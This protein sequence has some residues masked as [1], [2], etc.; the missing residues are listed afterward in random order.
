MDAQSSQMVDIDAFRSLSSASPRGVEESWID[1]DHERLRKCT[2][3][4]TGV[5]DERDE[6]QYDYFEDEDGLSVEKDEDE[7][8]TNMVKTA[9][10]VNPQGNEPR[11][12][13]HI[14]SVPVDLNTSLT[15]ILATPPKEELYDSATDEAAVSDEDS[16]LLE[17]ENG[18]QVVFMDVS[19][20]SSV[21]SSSHVSMKK[22]NKRKAKRPSSRQKELTHS[23]MLISF[24]AGL[25]FSAGYALGKTKRQFY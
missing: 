20:S 21:V 9:R 15:T 1:L 2:I 25:S 23:I 22:S 24:I 16:A 6:D 5:P 10:F 14:S 7:E 4:N 3:R 18:S 13:T 8:D 19:N 12:Q 11:R 17:P